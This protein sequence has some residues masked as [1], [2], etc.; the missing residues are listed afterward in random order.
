V[1][2]FLKF[3]MHHLSNLPSIINLLE[4][5][6]LVITIGNASGPIYK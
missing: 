6:F 2:M 1:K 4:V 3:L 5:I